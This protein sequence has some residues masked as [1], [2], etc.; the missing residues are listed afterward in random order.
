M[1]EKKLNKKGRPVGSNRR[2]AK[3]TRKALSEEKSVKLLKVNEKSPSLYMESEG[4]K[5]KDVSTSVGRPPKGKEKILK[6]I[7]KMG[8]EAKII[9]GYCLKIKHHKLLSSSKHL[10]EYLEQ[11]HMNIE[12]L[13]ERLESMRETVTRMSVDRDKARDISAAKQAV[14]DTLRA[15]LRL[16]NKK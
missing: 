8:D 10:A 5:H 1:I 13:L 7:D 4:R 6:R 2:A 15:E 16:L 14:I 12:S 3:K 9:K 11:D